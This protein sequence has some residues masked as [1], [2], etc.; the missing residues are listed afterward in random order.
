MRLYGNVSQRN[1][2]GM[3]G[4]KKT[5]LKFFAQ[6]YKTLILRNDGNEGRRIMD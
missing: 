1:N 2:G 6:K 4:D 3:T 5:Q